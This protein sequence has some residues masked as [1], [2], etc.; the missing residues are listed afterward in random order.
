MLP[1][2]VVL[3]TNNCNGFLFV[4]VVRHLLVILSTL[5][6]TSHTNRKNIQNILKIFINIFVCFIYIYRVIIHL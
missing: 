4:H 6:H 3:S 2:Y 1:I 5:N